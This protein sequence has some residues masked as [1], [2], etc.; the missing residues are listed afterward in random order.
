[1]NVSRPSHASSISRGARRAMPRDLAGMAGEAASLRSRTGRTS[2]WVVT[3][4]SGRASLEKRRCWRRS[5]AVRSVGAGGS[6][7]ASAGQ[8]Q[9]RS[10]PIRATIAPRQGLVVDPTAGPPSSTR[11]SPGRRLG[12]V[13]GDR[14]VVGVARRRPGIERH[15]DGGR[16]SRMIATRRAVDL[17]RV[18][19]GEAAVRLRASLPCPESR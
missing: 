17:V 4:S 11:S 19:E 3:S 14:D 12:G 8:R 10:R 2:T 9:H 13:G 1:M 6:S 15:D 7:P 5:S 16:R 18:G